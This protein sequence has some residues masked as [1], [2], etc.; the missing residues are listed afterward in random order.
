MSNTSAITDTPLGSY[1]WIENWIT[2]PRSPIGDENG[3]THGVVVTKDG[4]VVIFHQ[5]SPAV[6]FYSP[7]GELVKSWG[8]YPGAHGIHIGEEGG[9]EYLW[10]VDEHLAVAHKANLD[11]DVLLSIKPELTHPAYSE[12]KYIPTWA[13][14]AR[15]ESGGNGDI[16][17]V[18]G[19]G[20]S[21]AHRFNSDGVYIGCIDGSDGAGRFKCPHGCWIDY[22]KGEPELYIADR[23]NARVQVFDIEG[24]FKRC[25][26]EDFMTSPDGFSAQGDITIIPE[27][28]ARITLCDKDDQLI[29]HIGEND[30]ICAKPA[31]PQIN[32]RIRIPGKCISPHGAVMDASGNIY[33][34]EWIIGGRVSK[35]RKI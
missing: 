14:Q 32:P 20:A 34:A 17:L 7:D 24:K 30:A 5:A 28:K 31:W 21:V 9:D 16:W 10:L 18:D 15:A 29:C 27:L 12:K 26:G 22:S 25:F 33:L 35:L 19:Y 2:V 4:H 13:D 1:E 8:D 23:G 3:R 11:G 6:L